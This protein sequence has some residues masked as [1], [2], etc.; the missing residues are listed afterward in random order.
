MNSI[1]MKA[2]ALAALT[3]L[4]ISKAGA[5]DYRQNPF[6]LVYEGALTKNEPDKVNIKTVT[7]K[8]HGLDIAANVYGP[9]NFD[10]N[11]RYSAIVVAP[12]IEAAT[13]IETYWVPTY[14]DAAMSKLTPFFARTL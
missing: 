13:H 6:S 12:P 5:A 8:L 10:S 7:Y 1:A 11:K 3:G 9:A 4:S 2:T 14:V